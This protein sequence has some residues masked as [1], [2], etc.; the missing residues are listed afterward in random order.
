ML[1]VADDLGVDLAQDAAFF[2]VVAIGLDGVADGIDLEAVLLEMALVGQ[3]QIVA[4]DDFDEADFLGLKPV[5]EELRREGIGVQAFKTTNA[6]KANIIEGLSLAIERKEITIPN[7]EILIGELLAFEGQR[8]ASGMMKYGA[9][10]GMHDDTVMSLA[11][12]Y[13]GASGGSP[14][15]L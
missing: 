15:L 5:I 12:A 13:W 8:M 14:W 9:P 10:E 7:H 1:D 4:V 11:L 2:G 3:Q 6:S